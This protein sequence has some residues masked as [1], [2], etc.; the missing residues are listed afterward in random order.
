LWLAAGCASHDRSQETNRPGSGIAEYR[1]LASAAQKSVDLALNALAMV[2]AQSDRCPPE[3]LSNFVSEVRQLQVE[4]VQVRARSQA[5]Q[6]RGDAYFNDWHSNLARVEDPEIRALAE[7]HHAQLAQSFGRIKE[8]SQEGHE[9]FRPFIGA[10]RQLRNS[11]E[12][13]PAS[14]STAATQSSLKAAKENG[15][16]VGH[17]L[18]GI[19]RELDSMSSLI[20][21]PGKSAPQS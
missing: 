1:Q 21:P 4:S 10:L 8:L 12:K 16:R 17:F 6:A 15:Q 9:N 20:T 3:V 13:D 5:M 19:T 7:K 2:S 11:L 18:E 14:L